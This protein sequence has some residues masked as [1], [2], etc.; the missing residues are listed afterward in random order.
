M[1]GAT[2]LKSRRRIL[3]TEEALFKDWDNED[4]EWW[5]TV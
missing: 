5:N 1:K 4:D 3:T 2:A